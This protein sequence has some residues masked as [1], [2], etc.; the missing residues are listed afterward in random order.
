MQMK[1]LAWVLL[2]CLLFCTAAAEEN[3]F[4]PIEISLWCDTESGYEWSCEYTDNGVLSEPMEEFVEESAGG[5]HNFHFGVLQ[6]GW[7]QIIFNYGQNWDMSA[8]EKTVICSV[9][10]DEAGKSSVRWAE[11]YSDDHVILIRLPANPTT[12]WAWAYQEDTEGMVSLVSEEYAPDDPYLEGAGGASTYQ[13]KVNK[14]GET[15]LMFNYSN[16]WEPGAAAQETYAV[17]VTANDDM[18]I[19]LSI[20]EE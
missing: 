4:Q 17:I 12:G 3:Q 11:T 13:L 8:P 10:V 6:S 14:P 18:E 9:S 16:L 2:C 7:A 20:D 5:N 19:S 15:V 1:K